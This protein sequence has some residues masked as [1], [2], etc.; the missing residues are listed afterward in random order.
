MHV[1]KKGLWQYRAGDASYRRVVQPRERHKGVQPDVRIAALEDVGEDPDDG[2]EG[3][4][5]ESSERTPGLERDE[6]EVWKCRARSEKAALEER[7]HSLLGPGV[8]RVDRIKEASSIG[9][10]VLGGGFP[11]LD[12]DHLGRTRV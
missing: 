11:E 8:G 12:V 4:E 5:E 2:E 3:E 9:V 7:Y 6:E 1:V 10:G